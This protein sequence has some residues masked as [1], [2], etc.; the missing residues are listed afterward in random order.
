MLHLQGHPVQWILLP[1]TFTVFA[2]SWHLAEGVGTSIPPLN[3]KTA[4][5]GSTQNTAAAQ[6]PLG[7]IKPYPAPTI[8]LPSLHV[9][10]ALYNALCCYE[11]IFLLLLRFTWSCCST[12]YPALICCPIYTTIYIAL[13]CE[14]TVLCIYC[15]LL[16]LF[17]TVRYLHFIASCAVLL[18]VAPWAWTK[19]PM[20]R[21]E[22]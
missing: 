7:L 18:C 19:L 10:Y 22:V 2:P 3:S 4:P 12:S 20:Y 15:T 13:S 17:Y 5:W 9:L 8:V 11:T 6:H 21:T 16:H 14:I 1:T